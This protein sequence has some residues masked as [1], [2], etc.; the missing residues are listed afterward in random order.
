MNNNETITLKKRFET[1]SKKNNR[2]IFLHQI[3]QVIIF[4][5]TKKI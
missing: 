3:F 1:Q 4:F 5:H 2:T